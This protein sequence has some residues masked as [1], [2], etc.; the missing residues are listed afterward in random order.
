MIDIT[1]QNFENDL[2]QASMQQP[3]LLDIWAPWCGPCKSLGPMLEKLE[4]AYAGRFK[5]AKLDSDD[6]PEIAGQLSQAFGVRSIPFCVMFNQGQPVDGFVGAI[7]ESEIRAFLDKHV[8]GED[9]ALA[10]SDAEAAEALLAEGDTD[11]A[12]A[13]LQEA[14]A[15]DPANESARF[16][17]LR[18]LI[19]TSRSNPDLLVQARQ[20]YQPVAQRVLPNPRFDAI[21]HWL[22]A[23]EKAATGRSHDELGAAIAANKRDFDARFE[24]AQSYFAAGAFTQALDELLEILMRDKSWHDELARKA[25]VGIL[26][27]MTKPAPKPVAEMAAA[28]KPKLE[29]TGHSTAVGADPVIDQYRRRLSMTVLS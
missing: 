11:S 6:Q 8:P 7:P 15:V 19:E 4:T 27:L 9:E 12:L 26:E 23:S 5:L 2:L 21:G 28:D 3:I 24:L 13:K 14:V 25:Y 17:Y 29:L 20:A 1:L 10:E 18:L 16:D 22:D